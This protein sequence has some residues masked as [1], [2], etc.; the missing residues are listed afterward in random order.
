MEFSIKQ[1]TENYSFY[2]H[3]HFLP[4]PKEYILL[5]NTGT[6]NSIWANGSLPSSIGKSNSITAC[7]RDRESCCSEQWP[8]R[9]RK[10]LVNGT[11]YFVYK[12]SPPSRCPMAYCAGNVSCRNL[13]SVSSEFSVC[14]IAIQ[15]NRR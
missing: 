11:E 8:V 3:M 13:H 5:C 7:V 4:L 1:E 10:C 14:I 6:S 12:L 2:D 9:V 15:V